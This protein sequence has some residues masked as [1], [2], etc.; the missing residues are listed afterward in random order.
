MSLVEVMAVIVLLGLI[1]ATLSVG[2]SGAFSQGKAE[3]ARTSIGQVVQ[4]LELFH[5]TEGR[6]PTLD[7]GLNVLSTGSATPADSYFLDA[8]QLL[9]PWGQ[10]FVYITPGPD[11]RAYEVLS[12]GADGKPGGDDVDADIS[13]ASLRAR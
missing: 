11:L 9:D 1:A 3:L 10:A 4:K 8:E 6:W 13:S 2:F 7:E 5:V 12:Y